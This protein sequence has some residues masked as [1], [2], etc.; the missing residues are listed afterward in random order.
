MIFLSF[1]YKVFVEDNIWKDTSSDG[2][3]S[4]STKSAGGG[5]VDRDRG[6]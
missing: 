3:L 1:I 4:D 2:V 5:S 6:L